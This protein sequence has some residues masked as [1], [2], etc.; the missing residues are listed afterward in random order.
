MHRSTP[1]PTALWPLLAAAV[2]CAI[3]F[4]CHGGFTAGERSEDTLEAC[5]DGEDNDEDGF[6]DCADEE[7]LIFVVCGSG[8]GCCGNGQ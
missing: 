4:A 3:A 6:T 5:Q 7:C 8:D 2:L 1:I